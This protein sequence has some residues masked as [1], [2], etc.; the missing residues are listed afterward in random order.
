MYSSKTSHINKPTHIFSRI[1]LHNILFLR[2]T[3]LCE[4]LCAEINLRLNVHGLL[5]NDHKTAKFKPL[6]N[7]Y[8][9][10]MRVRI[11]ILR[12]I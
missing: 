1:Q 7:L 12:M 2:T 4:Q 8:K 6:E 10:V 11:K 9:Y 3:G 5:I